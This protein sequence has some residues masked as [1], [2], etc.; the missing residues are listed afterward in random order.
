MTMHPAGRPEV[1]ITLG[2]TRWLATTVVEI[3]V[4]AALAY[5]LARFRH[6]GFRSSFASVW[7]FMAVYGLGLVT[8]TCRQVANLG[9]EV[10]IRGETARIRS[11]VRTWEFPLSAV[12]GVSGPLRGGCG[13]L[14][15]VFLASALDRPIGRIEGRRWAVQFDPGSGLQEVTVLSRQDLSASPLTAALRRPPP[16]VALQRQDA[17]MLEGWCTD[18]F[19]RHEARWMSLGTPTELVRDGGVEGRDPVPDEPFT[20]SP[21]RVEGDAVGEGAHLARADDAQRGAPYDPA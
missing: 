19:G 4:G 7:A 17:S 10:V 8:T 1:I 2:R 11:L 16:P 9:Y 12:V 13:R 15:P 20:T 5:P 21:R 14:T 6:W 18:P 3:L